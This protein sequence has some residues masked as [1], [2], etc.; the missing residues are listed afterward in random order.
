MVVM[1]TFFKTHFVGQADE[2][3]QT[4]ICNRCWHVKWQDLHLAQATFFKEPQD[5]SVNAITQLIDQQSSATATKSYFT[6]PCDHSVTQS[7]IL[8][9]GLEFRLC[10]HHAG[11]Y[12]RSSFKVAAVCNTWCCSWAEWN[13]LRDVKKWEVIIKQAWKKQHCS[14]SSRLQLLICLHIQYP[15]LW[16][17]RTDKM[18]SV[19]TVRI[20]EKRNK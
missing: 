13:R 9:L 16:S 4:F 8:D 14:L 20:E 6:S 15:Q 1:W 12:S 5:F 18:T 2:N 3:K 17:F 10:I 19:E 7:C 11:I